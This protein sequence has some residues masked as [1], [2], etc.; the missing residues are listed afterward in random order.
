MADIINVNASQGNDA[1]RTIVAA[2]EGLSQD[3]ITKGRGDVPLD[4]SGANTRAQQNGISR[5]PWIMTTTEWLMQST[6]KGLIWAANPSDVSWEM[7]QRSFHSKNLFGTVLHVW[8]DPA[9]GTFF[10]EYRLTINFQSGN[11][12]P[13]FLKDSN[14]YVPAPGISNFYDFMQLVDAPKLTL[15]TASQPPRANLVH[16]LYSSNLFP[17]ITLLGMFDP[18]GIRFNDTSG[19]PN[20]V[21][22][23]SATFVVYDTA[24]KLSSFS[25]QQSNAQLEQIWEE[26]RIKNNPKLSTSTQSREAAQNQNSFGGPR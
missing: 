25:G 9:R 4:L 12:M 5:T 11:L 16:I 20:Q 23:W 14:R 3:S 7:S 13:V 6:P 21:S 2:T 8:P 15:G 22:S 1:F 18:A 19:E 10:D 17:K 26:N 24:P